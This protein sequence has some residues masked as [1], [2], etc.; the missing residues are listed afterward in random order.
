MTQFIK[1]IDSI[2][3]KEQNIHKSI[4]ESDK[5]EEGH[6]IHIIFYFYVQTLIKNNYSVIIF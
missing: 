2:L 6:T 1:R 3:D 5:E 4:D